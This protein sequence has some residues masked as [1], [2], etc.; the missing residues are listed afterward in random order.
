MSDDH[1]LIDP[2]EARQL[3]ETQTGSD[4]EFYLE[5]VATQL[6]EGEQLLG[7]MERAIADGD[8]KS[9]CRVAHTLKGSART[10]GLPRLKACAMQLEEDSREDIPAEP[11]RR[12]AELTAVYRDS[13]E[14]LKTF[15]QQL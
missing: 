9:F 3:Y 15:S 11:Q 2:Q 4:R 10:F 14:S 5:L 8:A 12:L 6:G 7:Q 1:P 13:M